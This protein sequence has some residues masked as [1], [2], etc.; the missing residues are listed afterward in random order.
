MQHG[1]LHQHQPENQLPSSL[2]MS[3]P[4][5]RNNNKESINIQSVITTAGAPVSS[6]RVSNSDFEEIT[7]KHGNNTTTQLAMNML[8][9]SFPK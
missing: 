4:V 1:V 9:K 3:T 6:D 7:T 5:I 2:D 8:Q